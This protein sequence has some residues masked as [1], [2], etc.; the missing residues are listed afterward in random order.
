MVV[1]LVAGASGALSFP[2]LLSG[3]SHEILT[4][5]AYPIY[6]TIIRITGNAG[7][8]GGFD[9]FW[10]IVVALALILMALFLGVVSGFAVHIIMSGISGVMKGTAK[11]FI[12]AVL[13]EKVND[14]HSNEPAPLIAGMLRGLLTGLVAGIL[15][16]VST[17]WGIFQFF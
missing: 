5:T 9:W 8:G 2:Q 14:S 16:A 10:L 1:G 11:E 7:A 15:M 17:I 4:N 13:E 3:A 6:E 12:S